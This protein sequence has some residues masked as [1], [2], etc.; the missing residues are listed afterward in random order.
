MSEYIEID[1]ETTDDPD[2]MLLV[3]NLTLSDEADEV[4]DSP[5]SMEEG[6]PLAQALAYVSG[7]KSVQIRR[8]EMV[9]T[10]DP[11]APWHVVVASIS[12]AIKDFFL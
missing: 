9:V 4:Y 12:A 5:A 10:R 1:A 11:D 8:N 7:I 6:T 2:R 3:T